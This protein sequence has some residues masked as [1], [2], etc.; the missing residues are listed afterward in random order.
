MGTR[1]IR[2]QVVVV[3]GAAA[4]LTEAVATAAARA[5]ARVALLARDEAWAGAAIRAINND[6]GVADYAVTLGTSR[7][8]VAAAGRAA[9]SRFGRIDAWID[10]ESG[11]Q[12]AGVE[13]AATLL[14]HGGGVIV[15]V[16][17]AEAMK[18]TLRDLIARTAPS[19]TLGI[20]QPA[21]GADDS[22]VAA[23]VVRAVERPQPIVRVG[24]AATRTGVRPALAAAVGLGVVAATAGLVTWLRRRRER[25]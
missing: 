16:A 14:R 8:A 1:P 4:P 11:V 5:G 25:A 6:G 24:G 10:V 21:D 23:A 3:H 13:A 12:V 15:A 18:G 19:V 17:S 2:D 9:R 22:A 7:E 20:V